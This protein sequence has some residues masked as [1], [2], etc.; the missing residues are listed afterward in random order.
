[1]LARKSSAAH[2]TNR[3]R[4]ISSLS[5]LNLRTSQQS[6]FYR[7]WQP[8]QASDPTSIFLS[9]IFLSKNLKPQI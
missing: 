2:P 8:R 5:T 1:M 7:A 9:L 4:M 3:F 6:P